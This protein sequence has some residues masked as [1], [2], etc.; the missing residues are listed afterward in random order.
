MGFEPTRAQKEAIITTDQSIILNAGAGSGKT[1]VL[2]ER[3]LYLISQRLAKV[4]EILAITFTNKAAGEMKERI[5]KE[6]FNR[7]L[8]AQS[9]KDKEFWRNVKEDLNQAWISTFHGFCAQILRENPIQ[10]GVDP[11]FQILD[12]FQSDELLDETIEEIFLEGLERDCPHLVTLVREFGIYAI[13]GLL[14]NAYI[15]SRRS[16]LTLDDISAMTLNK[17]SASAEKLEE[18]KCEIFELVEDLLKINQTQKL[19]SATKAKLDELKRVWPELVPKIQKLKSLADPERKVFLKLNEILKGKVAKVITE[20]KNRIKSI[21]EEFNLYL[22]DLKAKKLIQPLVEILKLIDEKYSEKKENL[23]GLDFFDLQK[24]TIDV[25][26]NNRDL[27]KQLQNKYK[28]IMVDEFQDTNLIQEQLIR[29]LIGGSVDAAIEGNKLFIVGDPKQSIY[30]FRG[31][32]VTVFKKLST[33]ISQV[34]R[35]IFLDKNF[36]SR[37]KIID[38]VNHFFAKIFGTSDNPYDMEYKPSSAFRVCDQS[39]F[40][41]EFM[42]L[43]KEELKEEEINIRE[44]EA[45]QLAQRIQEMV[46]QKEKLV[47]EMGPDGVEEARSVR[48]GDICLLF[49]AL[50]DVQVYEEAFQRYRIPYT[51]VNGRGF[52]ERQ[53]IRDLINLL[54]VVD[55]QYREIEW[56]GILRSP[57]LGLSD[58]DLFWLSDKGVEISKVIEKAEEIKGLSQVSVERIKKFLQVLKE[59]RQKRERVEISALITELL[60]ETGYLQLMMAHPQAELIRANLDKFISMARQYEHNLLSSLA[61]F[62]KYI[63]RLE[64]KEAREGMAQIS[65]QNDTVKLMTIHQSKGLEFPVVILPDAQRQLINA[66]NFPAVFFDAKL[67]LGLRVKDP[68][69]GNRI[70]TSIHADIW[71][72]EKRREIAEKKRLFYVAVTRA[73]DYLLIS[74]S[75][76]KVKEK[77]IDEGNNWF[78]WLGHVFQFANS[79]GLSKTLRYGPD[80]SHLIRIRHRQTK[81]VSKELINP[82]HKKVIDLEKWREVYKDFLRISVVE[83]REKKGYYT[84]SVTAL[85]AYEK[86]P[87]WY[88]HRYLQRMP[89]NIKNPLQS[90]RLKEPAEWGTLI[91]FLCERIKNIEQLPDLLKS[92][93]RQLGFT[94]FSTP[95]DF[96]HLVKEV[97]PYI[98]RFLAREIEI[99]NEIDFNY[100]SDYREYSFNLVLANSLIRGTIDRMLLTHEQALV[101]DYKTNQISAVDLEEIGQNY[102]LQM[103]IYALAVHRLAEIDHVKCKLYFLIPD[104]FWEIEFGPQEFKKIQRKITN[105]TNAIIKAIQNGVIEGMIN[106]FPCAFKPDKCPYYHICSYNSLC[107]KL[108]DNEIERI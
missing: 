31:A 82:S 56:V 83:P 107:N 18:L 91:H 8:N 25:L 60:E 64:E 47:Y 21:E 67:G 51:V 94:K 54:K 9:P 58:E 13:N 63:E 24:L 86:C 87:R 44:E 108:M 70:S 55:N 49:Q 97:K 29:L 103:E 7:A 100:D 59:A 73:R 81:D 75:V 68:L 16:Q 88:Y 41:V 50:T 10:A 46:Q 93:I 96:D 65:G 89:S 80:G 76:G 22:A 74:G 35:K 3:Y 78:D 53:E 90:L 57:F 20:H 19:S 45:D 12:E 99:K 40:C 33:E 79:N 38:F 17:L 52:F 43:D 101:I 27:C 62:I 14:K 105:L 95:I 4:D 28:F 48:Y 71:E 106:Q 85:M 11:F 2:V 77:E 15:N 42:I 36:R 39:D 84:F 102:R 34:G 92:G 26:K 23:N 98:E 30:R 6:V 5:V 66:T 37:K 32:D 104:L 61:G 1:R 69:N 72:E